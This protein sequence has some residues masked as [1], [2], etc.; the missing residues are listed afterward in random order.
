MANKNS[1]NIKIN[2]LRAEIKK[3]DNLYY[4][5]NKPIITDHEYDKLRRGL[6]DLEQAYPDLLTPSSPT[7]KVG[8][9]PAKSF[10]KIK[11]L[12]PM[13]SLDNA[14]NDG[15]M[16]AFMERVEKR[17]SQDSSKQSQLS[18]PMEFMAE[19]KI[20][21]LSVSCL[22]DNG[23]LQHGATRGNGYIGE[24]IT[25]NVKTITDIPHKIAHKGIIEVRGE[26]YM[27]KQAFKD[28][29]EKLQSEGAP[30]MANPR[31]AAAGSLRQL[32]PNITKQRSL[33]FFAYSIA[34]DNEVCQSQSS[35][36]IIL[37]NWGFQ[38]FKH[39]KLCK[40]MTEITQFYDYLSHLR[41]DLA[42]EIDGIVYKINDFK[43][44][45]HL[46]YISR[47][48]RYAIARKFPALTAI[49]KLEGI[50]LQVGRTGA[51]TPV[52]ILEPVNL[53]GAIIS[54]AS[55]HNKDEIERKDIRIGDF[56]ELQ[57][58]GDVIPKIIGVEKQRRSHEL[59]KF[60]FPKNCPCCGAVLIN[61]ADQVAIKC[62]GGVNCDAQKVLKLHHFASKAA[63]DIA[64]L[65][66][67]Q[68]EQLVGWGIIT[69]FADIFTFT[70]NSKHIVFLKEQSGWGQKT[71]TNLDQAID[72]KRSVAF[73]TFIYALGIDQVGIENARLLAQHFKTIDI[74][75]DFI[76]ESSS[77]DDLHTINGIG[78]VITQQMQNYFANGQNI[79]AIRLLLEQITL[80]NITQS[81]Q[82]TA[83]SGKNIVFTGNL[84][85]STRTKAQEQAR[86]LGANVN[87]SVS[88]NTDLVVAGGGAGSKL[89]KAQELGIEVIDEEEW[90]QLIIK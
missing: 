87:S 40:N 55:L 79:T 56:V 8:A 53:G 22:Y 5:E 25:Q 41:D 78:P 18:M 46:G 84:V 63:F 59:A 52:A 11:H 50:K 61:D 43:L 65:G 15:E 77:F 33:R 35:L 51:I 10:Q 7:Q 73:H 27:E 57:R 34:G 29:N 71:I 26:V 66:V 64:G 80:Q 74:F 1:A 83:I 42:Y 13:L 9:S 36:L 24:N 12:K 45:E 30:I 44:Q 6:Q 19:P 60:N 49:T 67:K 76:K 23:V 17:L 86:R 21:G 39:T 72:A 38:V 81:V 70:K 16:H 4:N 28:L 68:M 48:P 90:Q 14:F 54:K 85:I 82:N 62:S 32:D 69:T 89:Q 75:L 2:K 20:D 3:H 31:N 37:Q 47:S 88:K 58:S